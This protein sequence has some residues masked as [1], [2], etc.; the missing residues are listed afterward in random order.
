MKPSASDLESIDE[1][2]AVVL[3]K[4]EVFKVLDYARWTHDIGVC[5]AMMGALTIKKLFEDSPNKAKVILFR[6]EALAVM[7]ENNELRNWLNA[8]GSSVTPAAQ[9]ALM[10]AATEHPLSVINGDIAF[11]KE[12]FLRRILESAEA[13]G[14]GN[15]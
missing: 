6:L 11:E 15:H 9:K 4:E 1:L 2:N 12:S 7:M 8:D 10:A 13:E 14:C 5:D 3:S